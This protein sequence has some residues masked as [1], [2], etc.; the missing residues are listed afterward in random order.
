MNSSSDTLLNKA[1]GQVESAREETEA[2]P[3]ATLVE[4]GRVTETKGGW[5][6]AKL[7]TGA[8]LQI[9]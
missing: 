5:W 3:G 9:Y 1:E 4:L 8:G 6:G 7:D 2:E